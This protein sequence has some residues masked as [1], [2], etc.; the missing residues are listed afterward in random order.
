MKNFYD[1][2]PNVIN[3]IIVS[4]LESNVEAAILITYIQECSQ[5]DS[6]HE[7][8]IFFQKN[9]LQEFTGLSKSK[10]EECISYLKKK[11]LVE[12]KPFKGSRLYKIN[13][14]KYREIAG[15]NF[16]PSLLVKLKNNAK[17][18]LLL[19]IYLELNKWNGCEFIAEI[20]SATM[21]LLSGMDKESQIYAKNSLLNKNYLTQFEKNKNTYKLNGEELVKDNII[22]LKYA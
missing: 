3:P 8:W 6:D 22:V 4:R 19:E 9:Q 17:A 20:P 13:Y 21:T 5:T 15:Y 11:L 1:L 7:G 16:K 14:L 12:T 10:I 2:F 18:A